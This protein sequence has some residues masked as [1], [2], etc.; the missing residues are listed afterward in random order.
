MPHTRAALLFNVLYHNLYTLS[1]HSGG[2][3]L[4]PQYTRIMK[5]FTS[6]LA[7]FALI[8]SLFPA[9]ALAATMLGEDDITGGLSTTYNDDVYVVGNQISTLPAGYIAGDLIAAASQ[10]TLGGDIGQ[11][12]LAAS[13]NLSINTNIGDDA[14]IAA[15]TL[16]FSGV[17][18]GDLLAAV[19]QGTWQSDTE[20]LGETF[21]T[22]GQLQLSGSYTGAVE[23]AA[24]E[25]LFDGS[26]AGDVSINAKDIT[27]GANAIIVG[28][29]YYPE[30]AEL[31]ISDDADI[32][33]EMMVKDFGI[34]HQEK[35]AFFLGFMIAFQVIKYIGVLLGAILLVLVMVKLTKKITKTALETPWHNLGIGFAW[36]FLA[37]IGIAILF[38]TLI[39]IPLALVFLS[40]YFLILI[41]GGLY[42]GIVLG[43]WLRKLATK[44]SDPH[45]GWSIMGVTLLFLLMLIPVAGWLAAMIVCWMSVG[46]IVRLIHKKIWQKR[47]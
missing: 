46:T 5:K 15:G 25:V 26:T 11:D 22:G 34:G 10:I 6:F 18:R 12:L 44:E 20:I 2:H 23:I 35:A 19:G 29:F 13:S 4:Q 16:S 17:V 42:S 24:E 27:I 7:I 31:V 40:L 14:R 1:K 36:I 33:G 8:I 47:S 9:P 45:W 30:G 39:G 37:P 3:S 32:R 38:G 43:T 28:N 41:L 21:V